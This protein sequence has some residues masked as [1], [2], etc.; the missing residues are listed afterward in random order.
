MGTRHCGRR[1]AEHTPVVKTTATTVYTGTV[2]GTEVHIAMY[3]FSDKVVHN[4]DRRVQFWRP[5]LPTVHAQFAFRGT[6][7]TPSHSTGLCHAARPVH[8]SPRASSCV[9]QSRARLDR[10]PARASRQVERRPAAEPEGCREH[11]RRP[12][13]AAADHLIRTCELGEAIAA[14]P[15]AIPAMPTCAQSTWC[16]RPTF[17]RP[18][19]TSSA[20]IRTR[21]GAAAL[22]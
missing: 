9:L 10:P 11:S 15:R 21:H 16:R 14:Y 6:R 1:R 4:V 3:N 2:R 8:T 22:G 17:G 19:W 12:P 7:G 5:S 20:S 13:P 18:C